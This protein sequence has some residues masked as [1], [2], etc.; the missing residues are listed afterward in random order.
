MT[1]VI[2]P[3]VRRRR[4][5][6]RIGI[7]IGSVAVIGTAVAFNNLFARPGEAA[8]RLIPSNALV[9]GSADL[10]PAPNQTL[11]FKKID[12]ALT[13]NGLDKQIDGAMTDL[14]VQGPAA[15]KIRPYAKRGVA[16]AMLAPEKHGKDFNPEESAVAFFAISD[17]PAV[18][19]IIKEH[20]KPMFWRGTRYH[21]IQNEGP[22]LMVVEDLLVVGMGNV[23]HQVELV[24]EGKQDSILE[25]PDF[26]TEQA[27]IDSDS[28]L[29]VFMA[30]EAWATFAKDAPKEAQEMLVSQKWIGVGLAIRD[31]GIAVSFNGQY[32]AEK[33]KWLQP[34]SAMAPI[35]SDLMD[36]LPSGAYGFTALSQPS[37]Y[38]ESF[39]LAMGKDNDGRKMIADLEKDLSREMNLSVRKDILPAFQGNAVIGIYPGQ[40]STDPAGVD[41][42]LVID[43][44][45]GSQ[46]AALA[47]R[48]RERLE[49]EIQEGSA[50]PAFE[51]KVDGD[52]KRYTL[53]GEA[54]AEF[55]DGIAEGMGDGGAVR[56]DVL[57]KD[58]T[59]TWALIGQTVVASSSAKLLDRAIASLKTREHGLETDSLWQG[60][61]K[62]LVNGQQTLVAFNIARMVEGFQNS[63][64]MKKWGEDG[65]CVQEVMDALKGLNEPF[66]VKSATANGKLSMGLFIPMEYDRMID[67]I[68]QSIED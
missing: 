56:G 38:F 3:R 66:A 28:N 19:K 40:S 4:I 29:K 43:D 10:S 39:E 21:Q 51:V 67:L 17:G 26:I 7:V 65:K 37:K 31:G 27:K 32:D 15:E 57:A 35:R 49:Q 45:Q 22:G 2:A 12:E 24:A 9:I 8:L 41:V 61:S 46:A 48:L 63:I 52:V 62:D 14:V 47:E 16:F 5:L 58:K 42:L 44:Q 34:L 64:D 59:I 68:G 36:I 13:R 25:R 53:A 23:L 11:V 6:A 60:R 30:P 18:S 55:Q 50:E 20:G 54:A 33:A 1:S